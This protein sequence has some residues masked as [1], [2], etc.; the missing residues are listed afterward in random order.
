[1]VRTRVKLEMLIINRLKHGCLQSEEDPS[2][3][4]ERRAVGQFSC[5][6]EQADLPEALKANDGYD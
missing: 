1:M 4:R 2:S 5:R 3:V 6:Y